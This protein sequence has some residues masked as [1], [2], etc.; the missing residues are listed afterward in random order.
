MTKE[1]TVTTKEVDSQEIEKENLALKQRVDALKINDKE[2][3][4]KAG[5]VLKG[6]K[7]RKKDIEEDRK[8][9]VKPLNDTVKNIN[10]RYKPLI[11]EIDTLI[12][13]LSNNMVKFAKEEEEREKKRR[14]EEL[15]KARQEAEN[16][17][18]EAQAKLEAEKLEASL[19][20]DN[21]E[22]VEEQTNQSLEN[23]DREIAKK[24]AES[25]ITNN[26]VKS[27]KCTTYTVSEW[28]FEIVVPE[29]VP[30]LYTVPCEK[31]IREAVKNGERNIEGV[32]I[33]ETTKIVSR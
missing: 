17:R 27:E 19:F 18:A 10:S 14:E 25:T 16:A 31:K 2:T 15:E 4:I 9:I 20:G 7:I 30:Y 5:D 6:L 33:Y 3:Y 13:S 12:S 32:K 24:E 21:V 11:E 26:T 1:I 23:I 8:S 29:K 22:K 28:K